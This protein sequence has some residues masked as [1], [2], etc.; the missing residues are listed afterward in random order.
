M[1]TLQY[2][3]A[4][5]NSI[6]YNTVLVEYDYK[7][8]SFSRSQNL[9]DYNHI[10]TLMTR[11]FKSSL[12]EFEIYDLEIILYFNLILITLPLSSLYL[13]YL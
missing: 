8:V 12:R 6:T 10:I 11:L 2:P 7:V 3:Q 4:T 5:V 9:V 1:E 13:Y